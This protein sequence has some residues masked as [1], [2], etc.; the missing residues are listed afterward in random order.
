LAAASIG[1]AGDGFTAQAGSLRALTF[2]GLSHVNLA[3]GVAMISDPVSIKVQPGTELVVSAVLASPM[4]NERRG[5]AGFVRAEGNQAMRTVLERSTPMKGRPLV[6]GVEV[7]GDPAP[8]VIVTMGD[9]IT[10]GKS[11]RVRKAPRLA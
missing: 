6:S 9:S 8:R 7:F 10:D 4:A 11:C 5:G 1:V 2:G 3:A